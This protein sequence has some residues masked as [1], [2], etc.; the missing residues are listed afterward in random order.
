MEALI[1]FVGF[2]AAM[3]LL[4]LA[5]ASWGADSRDLRL[6]EYRR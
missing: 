5:A 6:D 3:V 2:L 4:G 1:V